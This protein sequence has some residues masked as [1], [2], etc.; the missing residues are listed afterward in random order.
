MTAAALARPA[1][2][3]PEPALERLLPQETFLFVSVDA[4]AVEAGLGD[5]GVGRLLR[6]PEVKAFLAPL[7]EKLFGTAD[8]DWIDGL[9]TAS[10]IDDFVRGP[11]EMGISGVVLEVRGADGEP[12]R[13]RLAPG[14][15]IRASLVHEILSSTLTVT[16]AS[17]THS[18]ASDPFEPRFF[19]DALVSLE[20]GPALRGLVEARLGNLPPTVRR[21]TIRIEGRDVTKLVVDLPRGGPRT[22]VYADLSGE[23]WLI[24]GDSER[25]AQALRGGPESPLAELD[26][27]REAR[28]RVVSGVPILYA[29]LDAA[30]LLSMIRPAVPPIVFEELEILGLD[31]LGDLSFGLSLVEGGIRESLFVGMRE[32]RGLTGALRAFGGGLSSLDEAPDGTVA[33]AGLR[34]DAATFYEHLRRFLCERA[35]PGMQEEWRSAVAELDAFSPVGPLEDLLAAVGDEVSVLVAPPSGGMIPDVVASVR[36]RD[37]E[38][39][40]TLVGRL[41][42]VLSQSTS[43]SFRDLPESYGELAFVASPS[44]ALFQPAFA[45]RDGTL[46]GALLGPL[47]LR[48]HLGRME[49]ES[50]DGSGIGRNEAL[51]AVRRA[52]PFDGLGLLAYIDLRRSIPV[53]YAT[54]M[55][56]LSA[57][58]TRSGIPLDPALMPAPGTLAR[59][60][61]GAM[62]GVSRDAAGVR[63]DTFSPAGLLL[64]LAV[65]V[66]LTFRVE[67]PAPAPGVVIEP[68]SPR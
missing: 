10:P 12:V 2:A 6:E 15:P 64:P 32:T 23:R 56:F 11:V 5:L 8:A 53:A 14:S 27:H 61:T 49:R 57:F 58:L 33:Y 26:A 18:L 51:A 3:S 4:H 65:V 42:E 7:A 43:I 36:V 54:G 22:E 46:H 68:E 29:H 31:G 19:L 41:R 45:L 20:P 60:F 66:P 67:A 59:H 47:A 62:I 21:E 48:G 1:A 28:G 35:L 40:A 30:S 63:L 9:R 13:R 24:A 37:R 25:L 55:P 16:D 34:F 44:G 52:V 38:K 39:F 17:F 50:G